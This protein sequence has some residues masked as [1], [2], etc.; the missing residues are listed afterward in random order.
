MPSV[1]LCVQGVSLHYNAVAALDG[2]SLDVP[3]GDFLGI[4]GPNGSGKTTFLRTLS[5]T[6]APTA[7]TILLDGEEIRRYG[8]NDL[9]R[10]MAVVPQIAV[11]SLDFTA[12]ELVR[13]GRSPYQGRWGT[14]SRRDR[15]VAEEAMRLTN[16][17]AFESR[18]AGTLSGGEYQ[19]VLVARALAQEPQILLL[20]EPT[21]HLDLNAQ[22]GLLEL[23]HRL[24][25]ERGITLLAVLHDLNLAATYCH[26]L[27]LLS[28]GRLAALGSPEEVLT[29]ERLRDVYGAE[30]LIRRHPLTGRPM[31]MP[32]PGA[33]GA[34]PDGPRQRVH[35]VGGGGTGTGLLRALVSRGYPVTTGALNVGDSDHSAALELQIPV[36]EAPPFSPLTEEAVAAARRMMEQAEVIVLTDVPFGPG[37]LA[38][39]KTLSETHTNG[40]PIFLIRNS[41]GREWDFTGGE[42]KTLKNRLRGPH[43]ETVDNSAEA[44][45]ALL[46]L[47]PTRSDRTE[48]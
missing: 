31:V 6:L 30:V 17:L 28:Q 11:P 47:L 45:A 32:V 3:S 18:I 4:L 25:R 42:A 8:S 36:A 26:R 1:R 10:K 24:N 34:F 43:V 44:L 19:R 5:R 39:L 40:K 12:G 2:V 33:E 20:D 27:A 35:V 13:M 23:L 37:N 48:E 22:I 14:E 7:G 9:A 38:N 41:E 16:T 15:D 29:A 21:A 46:T